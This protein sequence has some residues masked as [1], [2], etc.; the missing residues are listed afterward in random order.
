[1]SIRTVTQKPS[2]LQVPYPDAVLR[3]IRRE[4]HR[5][6]M[7]VAALARH[8]ILL[9]AKAEGSRLAGLLNGGMNEGGV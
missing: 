4:A 7:S 6:E 3:E 2:P 9:G 5:Q 1:M 8:L